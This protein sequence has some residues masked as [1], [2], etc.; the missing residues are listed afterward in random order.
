MFRSHRVSFPDVIN[1]FNRGML[2]FS[3]DLQSMIQQ[4]TDDREGR[5]GYEQ[6]R[7]KAKPLNLQKNKG[8]E[9]K[10]TRWLDS[11][12]RNDTTNRTPDR[13]KRRS[14][15]AKLGIEQL[16][17]RQLLASVAFDAANSLLTFTADAGQ[18]DTVLVSSSTPQQLEIQVG[19]GDVI[20]LAGDAVNNPD[21]NIVST[22]VAGDLL[23]INLAGSQVTDFNVDLGDAND[24]FVATGL[25]SVA[26]ITVNGGGG[27][28]AIDFSAVSVGATLIGG[29]GGDTLTGGAGDDL[30][31][32]GGGDDTIDGGAGSDT[33]SFVGIGLGVTATIDAGGG[34]TASYGSIVE[35]FSGIENLIGTANNDFLTGNNSANVIDGGAGNDTLTGGG[36]GDTLLG[37]AGDDVLAG[38]GG[39]DVIDGGAGI[40]TNSFAG[41]GIGVTATIDAGGGGTAVYGGINE[42]FAGIENLTGSD[43]D[44][45]L[46]GNN[47]V[48]VVAGGL[49]NDTL[50]GAGGGDTLLGGAGD[51]VLAGGGGSDVIDGGAGIDTNSFA[52]I[53]IGVTATIDA[54]GGGTAVYGGI[55]ETFI[56][57]ENLTGSDNDDILTG[58]DNI[59]VI[60]GGLGN[61]ILTGAGGGDTLLGGAGDDVLVGGGGS[62]FIDGGTGIDTNS[63]AGIGIGVTAAIQDD[64]TGTAVYGG[65]NETFAGIEN[66]GGSDNDDNLTGN[67][68]ANQIDGGLG[69]DVIDGSGGDDVLLGGSGNDQIAGGAGDDRLIGGFGDDELNGGGGDDSLV[70]NGQIEVTVTNLATADGFSLTPVFLATQN[71]VYDFF[72]VGSA[73]SA[74]LERLAEDGTTGPR[75]AAALASGGVGE[76]RATEGGLLAPGD[77]RTLTFYADPDNP[78]TRYLSYTSMLI[79]SNDA[80][81]AN[82]SPLELDLFDDSGNLITRVG[83][84]IFIVSGDE[85]WDA[86][87]EVNDEIPG[88]TPLLG[89]NAPDTGVTENGVIQQHPGFQ[90]SARLGGPIGNVL[91]ARP[92]SDFTLPGANVLGI[93]VDDAVNETGFS[94]A[95][96]DQPLASLTTNQTPAEL[97]DEAIADRLYYNIH[98]SD[99]PGGEIRGQLL[100]QSDATTSGIRTIVLT[101]DLDGAQE[102]NGASESEATGQGTVT[103]TVDGSSVTYSSELSVEGILVEELMPVS[104]VSSIHIHNAAAGVNGPVIVDIVQDAGGDINGDLVGGGS[105]FAVAAETDNDTLIGGNGNDRLFGGGGDDLLDGGSG[106]DTLSGGS[107]DDT[108][109]GGIGDDVASGGAGDDFLNGA[110][111]N[112]TLN[113]DDGDDFFVGIGGTDIIDGG[114]GID[115]NS[116]EGIGVGVTAVLNED[117]SGTATY[118]MVNEAFVGIE[119]L[120]GS[121]NADS[122]TATGNS[123]NVIRGLGGDDLIVAGGGDD[124]LIGNDGNDILRGINGNDTIIG[125]TGNDNLIGGGGNDILLGEDGNDLLVGFGGTDFIDGGNG[126][127]TN[128][129]RGIALG[130]TASINTNG[131]GQASYGMV[132][133]SFASI[134]V[135]FGSDNDDVFVVNGSIGRRIFGGDGDDLI[136]G[137][138]GNDILFG[139]AGNDI[140][141]GRAGNDLVFG[142]AGNDLLNGGNGDDF[143]RGDDGD[144]NLTGGDG[145][146]RL[147]GSDGADFLFG[148]NGIDFL[149]GA[150][151]NDSL[152]GGDDDDELRGGD[153]DDLLVGGLGDDDLFGGFGDNNLIQ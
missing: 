80:F 65:I 110:G 27:S 101:A 2:A 131:S 23:E 58:N 3:L 128:S 31:V 105:A 39:S 87:T 141:R 150:S 60:D 32:G 121:D 122:L 41:I 111:G 37:G 24:A 33:N 130:V 51:D 9:M 151:G 56:R 4:D 47:G 55:N 115:T 12:C 113:G 134:E 16:E 53:G 14:S 94:I 152:F 40:D 29:S 13:R 81:I 68:S 137:G 125:G 69:N 62:D 138:T 108:L 64:G 79:P 78:L 89:Q 143:L 139:G 100:L 97:V 8:N 140:I 95:S 52:G 44:D 76:A 42:T 114:A 82:D 21:F 6:R 103:I 34:G 10:N 109:R 77:T 83:D 127:D 117:G 49:G 91:T 107:G 5:G 28:D 43:N 30:L 7:D 45:V 15:A 146:D 149:F 99:F 88:N 71:G 72:D 104:G 20:T 17:S 1:R 26:A 112:D 93:E 123:D 147:N 38:G 25:A 67:N 54:G 92:G 102:P 85:V 153:D 59:N 61:D 148:S 133:E 66:L 96:F 84:E 124:L 35:T 118:G 120:T 70:G 48:N 136:L 144:D 90:G 86:G 116:F 119:N 135:L 73:A 11:L 106:D 46:T 75:I 129:F 74:N 57:I 63:F 22:S 98:T 145:S 18:V 36:G 126:F 50:V 142:E 19:V 132:N